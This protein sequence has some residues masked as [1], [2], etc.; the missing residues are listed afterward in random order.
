MPQVQAI[1][2]IG[3]DGQPIASSMHAKTSSPTPISAGRDYFIAQVGSDAGTY[4][5]DVRA[6]HLRGNGDD[7]FDPVAPAVVAPTDLST[8]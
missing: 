1:V 4:V 5:S 3:R 7:F 6:P 8:A 2:I